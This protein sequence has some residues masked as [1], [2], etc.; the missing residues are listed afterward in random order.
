MG[1][2]DAPIKG[3]VGTQPA[4]KSAPEVK[5]QQETK[6]NFLGF[7]E[8]VEAGIESAKSGISKVKEAYTQYTG[9]E[10]TLPESL[11]K[12]ASG[13]KN[14]VESPIVAALEALINPLKPTIGKVAET[15]SN[16]PLGFGI[17]TPKDVIGKVAPKVKEFK[18]E[19]PR[20]Y[21][22]I[23]NFA[24]IAELIPAVKG[25]KLLKRGVK[26]VSPK[27]VS[28]IDDITSMLKKSNID[29]VVK[30]VDDFSLKQATKKDLGL[31]EQTT[32][33]II[34]VGKTP[35]SSGVPFLRDLD[36]SEIRIMK[37]KK[38]PK[39]INFNKYAKQA[40][41]KKRNVKAI[42]PNQ[43]AGINATKAFNDIDNLRK[44]AG[45]K[46]EDVINANPNVKIDIS[47]TKNDYLQMLDERIGLEGI[48]TDPTAL[49]TG[50]EIGNMV[51]NLPDQIS[52][53]Q[54]VNL[55]RNLRNRVKYNVE[56][57][58]RPP[59]SVLDGIV[60]TTASNI[61]NSLDNVLDGFK[62]ANE[63]FAKVISVKNNMSRVLGKQITDSG[64]TKHGAQVMKRALESNA[65]VGIS[66]LFREV[67]ELTGGKYDLFQDASY[68]SIAMKH[69][70]DPRQVRM[71]L[72][73][74]PVGPS[75]GGGITERLLNIAQSATTGK[76]KKGKLNRISK[77]Y[78]KNQPNLKE[79]ALKRRINKIQ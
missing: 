6:S 17:G 26:S 65:D 63:E 12:G 46:I 44:N 41:L 52:A 29:D 11:L 8:P 31:I 36:E 3:D 51:L 47:K 14:V 59:N 74:I 35:K 76:Y 38:A 33:D 53:K 7:R 32:G 77:W 5:K 25:A 67:K 71:A 18:E 62:E 50:E 60:K 48:P 45:K 40:E 9:N 24:D 64:I 22:N 23:A 69:S 15:V 34:D 30:N 4:W 68:A 61:D 21:E 20:A 75:S 43:M 10:R 56:G 16:V 70:G 57:Q 54:A 55:K 79:A 78:D 1:W 28:K 27:I 72:Y 39:T 13:V 58:L 49:K 66:D 42:T 19:S 37:D 73:G 2:Q